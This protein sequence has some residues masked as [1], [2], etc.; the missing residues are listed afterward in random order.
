LDN[1]DDM[2]MGAMFGISSTIEANPQPPE[3]I[4]SRRLLNTVLQQ[5]QLGA[6]GS[7]E[8]GMPKTSGGLLV[9][10]AE[11][12]R[13]VVTDW[14]NEMNVVITA[15]NEESL[16]DREKYVEGLEE[17]VL[18]LAELASIDAVAEDAKGAVAVSVPKPNFSIEEDELDAPA[19]PAPAEP[20]TA[21]PGTAEPGTA[22]PGT[23]EPAPADSGTVEAPAGATL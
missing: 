18:V 20:G 15:L 5:L 10:V 9:S 16:D 3:V 13:Q 21:E 7:R 17:Q 6:T 19:E 12:K 23:A 4:A 2:E 14:V 1:D 22:E 8:S 11:D